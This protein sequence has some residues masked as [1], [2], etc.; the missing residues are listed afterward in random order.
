LRNLISNAIKYTETGG[1]VNIFVIPVK[2]Q[3]EISISDDGVGMKDETRKKLFDIS[4]NITT[5]GTAN[6][7]GSGLGLVLCKEFVEKNGGRIWAETEEGKGSIF[8]FTLP[9]Q[10]ET[11]KE[12]RAKNESLPPIEASPINML[13]NI[14]C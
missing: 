6:E 12:N 1:N 9:N 11:I 3:I 4:T 7:K 13:K 14:N 10:T 8:Y 5:K 2:N